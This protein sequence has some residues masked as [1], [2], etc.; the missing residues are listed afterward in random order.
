MKDKMRIKENMKEKR[1]LKSIKS[2][3]QFFFELE[4]LKKFCIIIIDGA[5]F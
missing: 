2:K 4:L 5:L 1:Y 3:K